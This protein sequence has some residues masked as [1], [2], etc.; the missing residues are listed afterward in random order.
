MRPV[1]CK[2]CINFIEEDGGNYSCD[3]EYWQ[4]INLQQ[5]ILL[6]PSMFGC[7]EFEYN[8]QIKEEISDYRT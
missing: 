4:N 3:Y 5:A 7:I 8:L 1:I 2:N 6:S